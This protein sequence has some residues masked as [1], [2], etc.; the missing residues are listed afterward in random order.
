MAL[1]SSIVLS[2]DVLSGIS[3]EQDGCLLHIL[4]PVCANPPTHCKN[5]IACLSLHKMLALLMLIRLQGQHDLP[6]MFR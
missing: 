6:A 4:Q 1:Q 3:N 2:I 5:S